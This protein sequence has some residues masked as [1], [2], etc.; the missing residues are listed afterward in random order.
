MI[1][2]L[3]FASAKQTRPIYVISRRIITWILL[4]TITSLVHASPNHRC[5]DEAKTQAK[6]LLGFHYGTDER[7]EIENTIKIL[8]SIRNP[9]NNKQF[10]DVLE[11]WGY[12]YKGQYRIHLIY[13]QIKDEC[14][15]I[16]QEILEYAGL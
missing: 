12:V 9:A 10:F 3:Q 13:A 6:K 2:N 4:V 1:N 5:A 16:G 7:I 15:L 8:P 11:V 14:V